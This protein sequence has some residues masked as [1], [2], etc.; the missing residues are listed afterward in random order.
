M[1][2]LIIF[3]KSFF[4]YEKTVSKTVQTFLLILNKNL[5]AAV[6]GDNWKMSDHP[7]T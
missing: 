5:V 2:F 7:R 6:F 1:D 4:D 3:K